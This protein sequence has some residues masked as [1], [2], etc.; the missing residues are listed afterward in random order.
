MSLRGAHFATTPALAL[1]ASEE[2]PRF[3]LNLSLIP[4]YWFD[5]R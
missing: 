2:S 5:P 1:G 4:F 3:K